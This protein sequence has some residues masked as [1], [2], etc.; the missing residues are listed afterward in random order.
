MPVLRLLS[1]VLFIASLTACGGYRNPRQSVLFH[2]VNTAPFSSLDPAVEQG[3]GILVLHNVYETLT[4]Y[5][6]TDGPV[7]PCL[8]ESWTSNATR[9]DW[10]FFLRR[11]VLYH[12]GCLMTAATVKKSIDRVRFL[13]KGTAAIW[14]CVASIEA[15]DVHIVVFRLHYAADPPLI[16]SSSSAAYIISSAAVSKGEAWFNEGHDAGSGPYRITAASSTSVSLDAYEGYRGGWLRGKYRRIFIEEVPFSDRRS[17]YLQSGIAD[18]V[19]SPDLEAFS[20]PGVI[21]KSS[22]KDNMPRVADMYQ[23]EQ[24]K[25]WQSLIM[26]FNTE[27]AP[28]SSED[29]RKALAYAF[30]YEETVGRILKG[31]AARSNG[32]VPQGIWGHDSS[33]PRFRCDLDT[34]REYLRRSGQTNLTLTLSCQ[35]LT[36]GQSEMLELYQQNLESLGIHLL[37]LEV[38]QETQQKQAQNS[39]PE[40]R[41]DILL[42]RW[43]PMYADPIS[44]FKTLLGDQGPGKGLND[45]YVHGADLTLSLQIASILSLEKR[46]KAEEIYRN[47]QQKV[48]DRCYLIFL[49]NE[50]VSVASR[51]GVERIS[52][53]PAY[54]SC[55]SYYNLYNRENP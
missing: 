31:Q 11:D 41:E 42:L 10:T 24:Y 45:S 16:A 35:P 33:L 9:T 26:L 21:P 2:V 28:C 44:I 48:F 46:P 43:W 55:I 17:S 30:P 8:A 19:F 40:E 36:R 14:D 1:I 27:K 53:N 29:F 54:A 47:L 3:N 39:R 13:G 52:M 50:A 7:K 38:D 49:Y 18:I 15:R 51:K 23:L 32:M 5:D 25:S 12:D 4:V 34:A 20:I 22:P 6:D 37:L